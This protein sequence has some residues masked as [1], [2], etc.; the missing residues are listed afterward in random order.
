MSDIVEIQGQYYIRAN[1]S[2]A[3]ATVR[4]LKHADTF[5]MLDRHGDIRPL[6]FEV[7]GLFH[8]GTRFL[9]RMKLEINGES[10]LLLSSNVKEDNDFFVADLTNPDLHCG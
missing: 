1:S 10:P 4:V 8:E 9:S 3:D 6:G 7:Q 2:L 5:A